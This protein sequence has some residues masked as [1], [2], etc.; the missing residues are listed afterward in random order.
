MQLSRESIKLSEEIQA[1]IG[2]NSE[3]DVNSLLGQINLLAALRASSEADNAVSLPMSRA[4]SS[5]KHGRI[6]KRKTDTAS[7]MSADDRDSVA[8]ES[9]AAG[10]SPKVVVQA[11]TRLKVHTGGSRA[12]SVPAARE[13]SVKIEEGTESGMDIPGSAKGQ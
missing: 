8:A 7:I 5:S 11:S 13:A 1:S 3:G 12:G 10:P 6:A 4:A 2:G 9:P